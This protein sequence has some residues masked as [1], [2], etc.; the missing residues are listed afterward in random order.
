MDEYIQVFATT[1]KKED[2]KKIARLLVQKKL[3]G[4]VQMIGPISSTYWWKDKVETAGEWLCLIKTRKSLFQELEKAIKKIH[5]YETPE[6][7]AMPIVSGSKD[8][9]KWLD[10]ELSKK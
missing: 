3:A 5:P 2:A 8:Y 6:I 1:E 4:C 9:L 7:I 10:E